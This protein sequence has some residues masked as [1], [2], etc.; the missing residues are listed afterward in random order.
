MPGVIKSLFNY[1]CIQ[2][3][4]YFLLLENFL[5]DIFVL[6]FN[7]RWISFSCYR[8]IWK[9]KQNRNNVHHNNVTTSIYSRLFSERLQN[10]IEFHSSRKKGQSSGVRFVQ[11]SKKEKS[12][13]KGFLLSLFS[14]DHFLIAFLY[15]FIDNHRH[16]PTYISS[17]YKRRFE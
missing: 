15:K 14:S 6:F 13:W 1:F 2:G 17:I 11:R 4:I 3:C 16:S 7:C 10:E 9:S 12:E 8:A 5:A